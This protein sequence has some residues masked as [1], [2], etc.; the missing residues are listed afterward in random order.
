MSAGENAQ[1][2]AVALFEFLEK[3]GFVMSVRSIGRMLRE[4]LGLKFREDD[5]RGWLAAHVKAAGRVPD[6]EGLKRDAKIV[7]T[8]RNQDAAGRN[9]DASSRAR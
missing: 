4:E 9:R 6:A 8:G 1:Q 2:E 7:L 3:R 5:L